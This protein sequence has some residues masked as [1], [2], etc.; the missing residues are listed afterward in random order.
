ML[1]NELGRRMT[2]EELRAEWEKNPACP[3]LSE[4]DVLIRKRQ[5]GLTGTEIVIKIPAAKGGLGA[6]DEMPPATP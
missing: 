1:E 6:S 5:G 2:M 3:S 4:V